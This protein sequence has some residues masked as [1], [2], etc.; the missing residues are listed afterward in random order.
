MNMLKKMSEDN[1]EKWSEE[2]LVM[3]KSSLVKEA[4]C[5]EGYVNHL[6]KLNPGILN[7]DLVSKILLRRSL[8]NGGIGAICGLC[9]F[10]TLPITMPTNMY[11]TFK[12][13]SLLVM[14]IAYIYGWNIK[15]EETATDI[16]LVM[17]G[18]ASLTA[19][20]DVGVKT[21]QAIAKKAVDKYITREV[22][23]KVNKILTRKIITKAGEKSLI[24]F[25]KLVPLVGAPIGGSI[26][27][28]GTYFVGRTAW[29]FYKG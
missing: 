18:N 10:I 3:I 9:G 17:G 24:S 13:Q 25:T 2:L 21:G 12:I 20:K 7:E 14:S 5:V 29:K 1:I 23:K 8:K 6:R 19:L 4:D 26:D 15:D 16:L 28:F 22:M 27:F 11:Y